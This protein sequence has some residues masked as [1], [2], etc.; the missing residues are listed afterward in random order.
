MG[1]SFVFALANFRRFGP[2]VQ[3]RKD[4]PVAREVQGRKL[5]VWTACKWSSIA[6]SLLLRW[7]LLLYEKDLAPLCPFVID[8]YRCVIVARGPF[9]RIRA[10]LT[11]RGSSS[12]KYLPE[13][14]GRL[15]H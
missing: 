7:T 13:G 12:L 5:P 8:L 10:M 14:G 9:V 1:T 11:W 2:K 3:E 6:R 15:W 4:S